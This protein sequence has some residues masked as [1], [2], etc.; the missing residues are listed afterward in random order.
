MIKKLLIFLLVLNTFSNAKSHLENEELY[1]LVWEDD[2]TSKNLD[3]NKWNYRQLGK[4][5][6]GF[7]IRKTVNLIDNNYLE[8]SMINEN[9]NIYTSMISTQNIKEFLYG[10]FEIRFKLPT[11]KGLQS[12]FWLQS[13]N[14]GKYKGDLKKSGVEIDIF[15]H[16]SRI[17]NFL[18]HTIYYDSYNKKEVKKH[19]EKT[20]IK[21]DDKWHTVGLL[22]DNSSYSFYYDNE[23]VYQTTQGISQHEEYIIL[24]VEHTNWTKKVDKD[25]E[26]D[27]FL[28]DYV[29]V[30]QKKEKK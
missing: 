22:W 8:L 21:L 13:R 30:Y 6:N 14:Y 27:A 3:E 5:K 29:K 11:Q 18:Y 25:F 1:E 17:P 24:S 20:P 26:K 7:N 2:F 15:E 12:A 23:L 10:Y 9:G 19:Q 4:R 28:I 16:N